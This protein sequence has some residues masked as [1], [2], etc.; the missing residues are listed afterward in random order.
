MDNQVGESSSQKLRDHK[1]CRRM[2][3]H[4]PDEQDDEQNEEDDDL[5]VK[6]EFRNLYPVNKSVSGK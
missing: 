3:K 6:K 5:N 2:L 1:N 4:P